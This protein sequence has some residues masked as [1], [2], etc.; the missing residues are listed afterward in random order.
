MATIKLQAVILALQ[1]CNLKEKALYTSSPLAPAGIIDTTWRNEETAKQYINNLSKATNAFLITSV[2]FF[3]GSSN[4]LL[5][6]NWRQRMYYGDGN[7]QV[8]TLE[9]IPGTWAEEFRYSDLKSFGYTKN[10]I[11]WKYVGLDSFIPTDFNE[12][13]YGQNQPEFLIFLIARRFC[14]KCV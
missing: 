12:P 5:Y 8:R 10:S 3:I 14:V 1:R 9:A 13:T 7:A 11:M 2:G 4:D 6:N